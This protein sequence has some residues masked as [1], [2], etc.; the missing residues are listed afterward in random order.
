MLRLFGYLIMYTKFGGQTAKCLTLEVWCIFYLKFFCVISQTFASQTL[1]PLK[2]VMPI[3][4]A[5]SVSG[6]M[7][8]TALSMSRLG[9]DLNLG[10]SLSRLKILLAFALIVRRE[11]SWRFKC[12]TV[13]AGFPWLEPCKG[14]ENHNHVAVYDTKT[15]KP[16]LKINSD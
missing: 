16:V 15:V 12:L 6:T 5:I 4:I 14:H 13:N 7:N 10:H 9:T 2:W 1:G 8:G 3:L 11:V